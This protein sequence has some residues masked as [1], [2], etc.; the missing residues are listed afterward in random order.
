MQAQ[1]EHPKE[2]ELREA[3]K[4]AQEALEDEVKKLA[5]SKKSKTVQKS[6]SINCV[7]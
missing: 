4:T 1:I 3:L 5:M 2:N 6:M 7:V